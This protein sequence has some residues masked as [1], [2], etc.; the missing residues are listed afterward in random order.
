MTD[1]VSIRA[2]FA[3]FFQPFAQWPDLARLAVW[4]S[5]LLIVLAVNIGVSILIYWAAGHLASLAKRWWQQMPVFVIAI[6][7]IVQIADIRQADFFILVLVLLL[8]MSWRLEAVGPAAKSL[9][10]AGLTVTI[11][12][13]GSVFIYQTQFI[14]LLGMIGWLLSFLLWFTMALTGFRLTDLSVRWLPIISLSAAAAGLIVIL[15]TLL[16]RIDTGF[17]PGLSD[18]KDQVRLVDN[19]EPGGMSDLL[20]DETV[21]FRAFPNRA[22]NASPDYWRVFVLD[23]EQN[24]KW[25]RRRRQGAWLQSDAPVLESQFAFTISSERHDM[26]TAPVPGWPLDAASDYRLN[27]MGEMRSRASIAQQQRQVAVSGYSSVFLSSDMP[28]DT[29]LSAANPQLQ[30]WARSMRKSYPNDRDFINAVLSEFRERFVYNTQIELPDADPLDHFFFTLRQGYCSTFAST[31]ATILRAAGIP[32]HIVTGYLGGAWNPYG[33]F[34]LVK[35]AD[36]HAWVEARLSNGEWLR[37]DPTLLVMPVSLDRF[38]SLADRGTELRPQQQALVA[39]PTALTFTERVR[40]AGLWVDAMN[41][42]MTQAILQ[43]GQNQNSLSDRRANNIIFGIIGSFI[44]LVIILFFVIAV[45]LGRIRRTVPKQ[46]KRLEKLLLPYLGPRPPSL[47]LN[48]YAV[49]GHDN[50]SSAQ[51]EMAQ[52]LARQIYAARFSAQPNEKTRAAMLKALNADLHVL[53]KSLGGL[54][55]FWQRLRG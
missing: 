42:R 32:A 23:E 9:S 49:L 6:W 55:A 35:N 2:L 28:T 51:M 31:M 43:Y 13:V 24:G 14:V 11:F 33:D 15:F 27:I 34:W 22:H 37:F 38:E 25:Q 44:A 12:L 7:G 40:Q 20:A 21:A 1:K 3:P 19:L 4:Q 45:R 46:E 8:P 47:S 53:G 5:P 50:L 41:I 48:D 39:Q 10:P 52:S 17:L 26:K 36:A 30:D 16:P 54:S 18:A 29:A